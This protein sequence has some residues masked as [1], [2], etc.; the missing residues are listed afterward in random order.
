MRSLRYRAS[1]P[2]SIFEVREEQ[3]VAIALAQLPSGRW[4]MGQAAAR[5]GSLC[6]GP[7]S[8][9]DVGAI[10]VE[11]HESSNEQH[12]EGQQCP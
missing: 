6:V 9:Q 10:A 5:D 7:V 12:A 4:R 3:T 11:Q 2:A 8:S 1:D